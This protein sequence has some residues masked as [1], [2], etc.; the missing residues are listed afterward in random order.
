M[1][2]NYDLNNLTSCHYCIYK[3]NKKEMKIASMTLITCKELSQNPGIHLHAPVKFNDK[4]LSYK[5]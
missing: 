1:N 3:F 5:V 2:H 4:T